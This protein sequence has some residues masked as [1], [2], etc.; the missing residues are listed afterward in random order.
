MEA[1]K[2]GELK[3]VKGKLG[4]LGT[5]S[6]QYDIAVSTAAPSLN[7]IVVDTT[8]NAQECVRFL[9]RNNLGVMTFCILEKI[10]YLSDS[11]KRTFQAPEHS[12]RLFDL[13]QPEK[14][15]YA[16]AFYYA[17]HDTLVTKE[18]DTATKIAYSSKQTKRIVT[19]G[20]A[21]I[22][23][24]GAMSGGGSRVLSGFM[25]TLDNKKQKESVMSS[26]D[27]EA[28]EK[29]VT[30]LEKSLVEI[31][32]QKE[33]LHNDIEEHQIR[34]ESFKLTIQKL[35]IDITNSETQSKQLKQRIPELKE[36]ISKTFSDTKE[37][38]KKQKVLY[39]DIF[40]CLSLVYF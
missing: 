32:I 11:L 13:I 28:L 12:T 39:N 8:E 18:L 17:L 29:Q 24:S 16:V 5:I 9:K 7:H 40:F 14:P 3:G 34:V 38:E 6:P 10:Q 19:E 15:E 23:S 35:Q 21:L 1:T 36:K 26:K 2:K 33:S 30:K 4:D 25:K 27:I 22:E 20:G 37:I 31:R